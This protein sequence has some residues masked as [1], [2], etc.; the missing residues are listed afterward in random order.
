MSS[1]HS[2][3]RGAPAKAFAEARDGPQIL[4]RIPA[5]E[6]ARR[7]SL[8]SIGEPVRQAG[9]LAVLFEGRVDQHHAAPLLGRQ[10]RFECD[11]AVE[12]DHF[13][14]TIAAERG[15]QLATF[16]GM[17]LVGDQHVL[18]AYQPLRDQRAAGIDGKRSGA[19]LAATAF[20]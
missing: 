11:P 13:C 18:G 1:M 2:T 4:D 20:R 5:D 8:Q 9:K 12:P 19:I 15:L 3:G 7:E 10:Q 16:L 14:A 17:Q 6:D